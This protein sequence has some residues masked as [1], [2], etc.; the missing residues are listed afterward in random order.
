M[1]LFCFRFLKFEEEN[2]KLKNKNRPLPVPR[3]LVE[4]LENKVSDKVSL[5]IKNQITSNFLVLYFLNYPVGV[6]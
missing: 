6:S 1:E 5:L 4:R 2:N 3:S